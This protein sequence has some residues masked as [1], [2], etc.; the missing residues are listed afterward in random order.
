ME[1]SLASFPKVQYGATI[2]ATGFVPRHCIKRP[3][4]NDSG[5]CMF[6][7]IAA[8]FIVAKRWKQPKCPSADGQ[9]NMGDVQ[10]V[11]C[12]LVIKGEI[13]VSQTTAQTDLD[14]IY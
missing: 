2:Q 1:E 10:A 12:H 14:D 6:M 8:L 11:G 3:E 9:R 7:F 13:L 4:N 5:I